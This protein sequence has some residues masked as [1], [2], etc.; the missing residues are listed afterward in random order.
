[1]KIDSTTAASRGAKKYL[2]GIDEAG[3]GP[4]AGPVSVGAFAVS[5]PE[6]L[7]RF[8]GVR[9][10]KQLT[11]AQ[12]EEWFASI[13]AAAEDPQSGVLYAVSFAHS[14]TIDALGLTKSIYAA[15]NRCLKK[16]ERLDHN[17]RH[18]EI[19]L[20]GLLHASDR[21][22]DQKTI[23]G[24]DENEPVIA[25]ASICAKVM[26]DRRMMKAGK[27]FPGY[28]FEFHKG[29]GTRAHYEAIKNLGVTPIHRRRFLGRI[30]NTAK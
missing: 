6:L 18:A 12:R 1:M 13:R 27:E 2:I 17:C 16:L 11:P 30:L 3:R 8:R 4:L 28:G 22:M 25:L 29:Y 26:R 15:I 23:I 10:S 9:D 14:E 19:R 21:Y 5:S 7:E 24:G 20:D